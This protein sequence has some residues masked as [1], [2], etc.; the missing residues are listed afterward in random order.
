MPV[1]F[2]LYG[3]GLGYLVS[4]ALTYFRAASNPTIA[5]TVVLLVW[6]LITALRPEQGLKRRFGLWAPVLA[7]AVRWQALVRFPAHSSTE[8]PACLAVSH[9]ALIAQ[10]WISRPVDS[11]GDEC[12][13]SRLTT[14]GAATAIMAGAA[15]AF[16]PGLATGFALLASAILMTYLLTRWFDARDGGANN[17]A[18]RASGL[19]VETLCMVVVSTHPLGM[20]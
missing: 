15:L 9:A 8:L 7:I 3:A 6:M 18:L 14:I 13:P 10:A 12:L 17:D 4:Y 16:L 2:P 11:T 20:I 1:L 19:L 5:A